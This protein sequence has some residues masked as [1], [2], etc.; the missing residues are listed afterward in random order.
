MTYAH[1]GGIIEE[2][3]LSA[4]AFDALIEAGVINGS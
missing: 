2:L 4:K 3:G 1:G